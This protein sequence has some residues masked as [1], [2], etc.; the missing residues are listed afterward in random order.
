MNWMK[1]ND[2]VE[3][4][5][6][7]EE[8]GEEA[9]MERRGEGEWSVF[10]LL[11]PSDALRLAANPIS[12]D[13]S[14]PLGVEKEQVDTGTEDGAPRWGRERIRGTPSPRQEPL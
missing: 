10:A 13:V 5:E 12:L 6:E 3:E 9:G 1:Y 7:E 14:A 8:E 11:R 2:V 4:E